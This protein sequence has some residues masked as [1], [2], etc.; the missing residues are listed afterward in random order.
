[1]KVLTRFCFL[2]EAGCVC[3]TFAG[4]DITT[5]KWKRPKHPAGLRGAEMLIILCGTVN[6]K[7]PL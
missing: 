7:Q 2:T 6:T 3:R 4:Q 1:M 5:V